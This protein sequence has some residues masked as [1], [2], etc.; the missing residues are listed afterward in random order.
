MIRSIRS[1][2][3]LSYDKIAKMFDVSKATI[4]NICKNRIYT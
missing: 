2:E 3:K 4:I 1:N